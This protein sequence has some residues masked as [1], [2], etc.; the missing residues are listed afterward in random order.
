MAR[1]AEPCASS[2]NRGNRLEFVPQ[3]EL[4][5]TRSGQRAR[6]LAEPCWIQNVHAGRIRI[7]ANRVRDIEG[8]RAELQRVR[9]V[10]EC[11]EGEPLPDP[12]IQSEEA[13]AADTVA[14]AGI[15]SERKTVGRQHCRR[16]EKEVR[17]GFARF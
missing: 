9:V 15:A 3:T 8:F 14:L 5:Y 2:V 10:P 13:I 6:V 12:E 16:I 1:A 7:E 17:T 4:K 11:K